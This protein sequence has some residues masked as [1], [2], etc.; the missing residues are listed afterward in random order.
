MISLASSGPSCGS[1][2]LSRTT[3]AEAL[4]PRLPIASA[5]LLQDKAHALGYCGPF[6]SSTVIPLTRRNPWESSVCLLW[7]L[8][9]GEDGQALKESDIGTGS[10][11]DFGQIAPNANNPSSGQTPSGQSVKGLVDGWGTPLFFSRWAV[12]SY[13]STPAPPPS[14]ASAR[15]PATTTTRAIPAAFWNRPSWEMS[16]EFQLRLRTS[17]LAW[18]RHPSR[19]HTH[20]WAR[21]EEPSESLRPI[22]SPGTNKQLASLDPYNFFVLQTAG[23]GIHRQH[24]PGPGCAQVRRRRT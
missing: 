8:Q 21:T 13:G 17:S 3:S 14:Q 18:S 12:N 23:S 19:S 22:V 7:A 24:I 6:T 2:R 1:S 9:R 4:E 5:E 16:S 10:L 11:K 15:R 20:G